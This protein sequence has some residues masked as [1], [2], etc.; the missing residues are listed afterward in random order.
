MYTALLLAL[1]A[2]VEVKAAFVIKGA[3][4]YDG[5]AA[6]GRK[7]DIAIRGDRIV[8]VGSFTAVGTPRVI[9]GSGLIVAPGFIDLH[10][11]SDD[12]LTQAETRGNRSYLTQ[13]VTTV[14]TG[15]CGFGPA[16]VGAYFKKL[17]EGGVGSNVIHQ[18]PHNS[19]RR[20][21]LKNANRAPTADELKQMEAIVDT[22]MRDGAWGLATGLIYNPGT[23]SRTD[24]IIA[25][26]RVAG[27][28]G[29]FY[30]SHIRSEGPDVLTA[31]EE[32]VRIGREAGLPVHISHMKTSGRKA[33]PRMADEIAL[34]EAARKQGQIVTADQYPYEASSTSLSAMVIPAVFREGTAKD[35]QARLDDAEL[36][37][38]V[39]KG[40]QSKLE[41]WQEGKAIRIAQYKVKPE[42]QGKDLATIAE[43]AKKK[44]L[45]IVLEI[46]RNGGAGVVVFSMSNENVRLVMKQPWVATAS[47]GSSRVAG[48][49]KPHPRSYGC[50]P[51]KIGRFA[52]EEKAIS[53]EH[54]IRSAS[55]L[56]A[57][58]LRLKERGYLRDG[59]F[60]DVVV[61]D[62]KT[63]RDH[64]TYDQPHQYSTGVRYLFVN[65][66]L[67]INDGKVQDVLAGKVLRHGERGK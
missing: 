39:R 14:V 54:A 49:D 51:R 44:A 40:I 42:W 2:D 36:G 56:P 65:G 5:T 31:A 30:A 6:A 8:A 17:E 20:K 18:V 23:Y 58:I 19:V 35:F 60:A 3:M 53:L 27:R 67:V 63:F 12:A 50:F 45:D 55:G 13:G 24:E 28:H 32:A 34:V 46:E 29:G 26:A 47:D 4:L 61:F 38:T 66:K 57:D 7:A 25:L 22:G 1:L 9:D 21:V 37:P 43:N 62:P 48:E 52:I 15:N 41:Y 33:W 59:Y 64:A 10:T 16:D 11:H